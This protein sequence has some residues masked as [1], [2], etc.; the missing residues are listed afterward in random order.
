M[1][2]ARGAYIAHPERKRVSEPNTTGAASLGS[3]PKWLTKEEKKVWKDIAKTL[4]PGVAFASDRDS[5]ELMVVLTTQQRDPVRKLEMMAAERNLLVTLWSR[6]GKTPADRAKIQAEQPKK[7]ELGD[8]L[9][10]RA[11][12]KVQ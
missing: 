3:P 5:F 10:S 1:L 11:S 2:D 4:L 8:F 6:F 12:R 7:S 9:A